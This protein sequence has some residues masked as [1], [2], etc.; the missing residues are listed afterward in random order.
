MALLQPKTRLVTIRL[1]QPDY[2]AIKSACMEEGAWSISEF[3]RRAVLN[4]L[5]R[6][7]VTNVTFADDL[8]TLTMRLQDL[9]RAIKDASA[10]IWELIGPEQS[11][12]PAPREG[13]PS[14]ELRRKA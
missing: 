6:A 2:E 3:A 8:R 4:E 9:D 7:G 10:R 5:A 13:Q 11:A 14:A 1:R 12:T